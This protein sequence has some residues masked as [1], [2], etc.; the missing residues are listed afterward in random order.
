MFFCERIDES[1][2]LADTAS[3]LLAGCDHVCTE[4]LM[5]SDSFCNMRSANAMLTLYRV[6]QDIASQKTAL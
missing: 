1:C 2:E 4:T 5:R 3:D 6:R